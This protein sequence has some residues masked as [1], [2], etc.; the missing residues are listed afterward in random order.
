[1]VLAATAVLTA[2][3]VSEAV[4]D[5]ADVASAVLTAVD[6][7]EAVVETVESAL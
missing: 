2:V 7:S 6:V 3:E 1:V 4:V 5:A